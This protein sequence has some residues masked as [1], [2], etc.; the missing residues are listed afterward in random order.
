MYENNNRYGK[1]VK[2]MFQDKLIQNEHTHFHPSGIPEPSKEDLDVTR[3]IDEA[4]KLLGIWLL[5]HII[6]GEDD[7]Y[8]SLQE[9][10]LVKNGYQKIS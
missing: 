9:R 6:I 3:R 5:D 1:S 7:S 2:F 10:G 4:G 8:V